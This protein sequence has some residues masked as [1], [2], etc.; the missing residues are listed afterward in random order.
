M[1][2]EVGDK[3]ASFTGGDEDVTALTL[4]VINGIDDV[5]EAMTLAEEHGINIDELDS[6]EEIQT[7]LKCH[8]TLMNEGNLKLKMDTQIKAIGGNDAKKKEHL[9]RIIKDVKNIFPPSSMVRATRRQELMEDLLNKDG[10]TDDIR[11]DCDLRIASLKEKECVI[12]VSGESSAGKSS[13]LN[14]LLGEEILPSH[15]LP[16]TSCITVIKY[17]PYRCAKIVYKNGETMPIPN[18]DK[19]GLELLQQRAYF[20]KVTKEKDKQEIYNSRK[21]GHEVAEIQVYLPIK[22]L[23][24]GLVL[25]DTP[26]IGENEF[27]E[28]YLM[29]YIKN[30]QILGFMYIIMT[31][32]ALGIAED[33]LV[34]LMSLIIKSQKSSNDVVKFNPKAALFVCN[35]WDMV[36]AESKKAVRDNALKQLAKAW[37]DFDASNAVFFST[38]HARREID[39]NEG[40]ITDEYVALLYG[41]MKLVDV[42]LDK[43]IKASY[44]WVGTVLQRSVHYLKTM[45]RRLDMGDKERQKKTEEV[46]AK[47]KTLKEKADD[48]IKSLYN[49]ME[50]AVEDISHQVRNYL[51]TTQAKTKLTT[52]WG[53]KEGELPDMDYASGTWQWIKRHIDTAFDDRLTD[54]LE[55]WDEQSQY[56][57]MLERKLFREAKLNLCDLESDL[58]DVEH[59]VVQSDNMSLSRS[60]SVSLLNNL[61]RSIED[62]E[63]EDLLDNEVPKKLAYRLKLFMTKT[64]R[65]KHDETKLKEYKRDAGKVALKRSEKLLESIIK[66]KDER[67]EMFV[68]DFLQRPYNYI[69]RLE[70][71]IPGL[72]IS[73]MTLL[74]KFEREILEEQKCRSQYV[75]MVVRI[76]K[77]R[78]EVVYY[79][80]ENFFVNDFEEKDVKMHVAPLATSRHKALLK[81]PSMADLMKSASTKQGALH[82]ESPHGLWHAV[83]L[84]EIKKGSETQHVVVKIYSTD[85]N[86]ENITQEVARLRCLLHSDVCIAEFLGVFQQRDTPTPALIFSGKLYSIRNYMKSMSD[87]NT[88]KI[89]QDILAGLQY[90][91]SKGL[92]HMELTKDTVTVSEKGEVKMTGGCLPR[93]PVFPAESSAYF[94]PDIVYLSPEVI[95]GQMYVTCADMY[96]FAILT[97]EIKRQRFEAFSDIPKSSLQDFLK[98]SARSH[99]EPTV[100]ELPL[101][102]SV[103][104][105]L[106]LCLERDISKRP[107]AS[108][109]AAEFKGRPSTKRSIATPK[110]IFSRAFSSKRK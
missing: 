2:T 41:L 47:L 69:K 71:K 101:S 65:K 5:I 11:Q 76:E 88:T 91:H 22:M 72:I 77:I 40:Y 73:N 26:G 58:A 17:N 50:V 89:L 96:A 30:H 84:G 13:L 43:R 31:D 38:F 29:E 74:D 15:M 39:V 53:K 55:E 46:S 99:L 75:D 66:D 64:I 37:P 61:C 100:L 7:R 98:I 80:E 93:V 92:V 44:R 87:V 56:I 83:H 95:Q 8:M 110:S 86:A 63:E 36:P 57:P 90:L 4:D 52:N 6:V 9:S 107:D 68:K 1:T 45:V 35:R 104:Q 102:Q 16:C 18:L 33:R 34:N 78:R 3:T 103:I 81:R 54:L 67:L 10:S 32:N 12:L 79:G 109:M 48:V 23:Y 24:S 42:S 51:H 19:E 97:L 82:S 108:N 21:E 60:T 27:L 14:L 25:V 70:S 62:F 94:S 20:S 59:D 85:A 105:N 49:E 28:N 106:L